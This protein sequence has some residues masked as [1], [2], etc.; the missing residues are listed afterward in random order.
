MYS[1]VSLGI[2]GSSHGLPSLSLW[3]LTRDES[4]L[5][6]QLE[7]CCYP[8]SHKW[9]CLLVQILLL[10]DSR[11]I[12]FTVHMYNELYST[13]KATSPSSI[14]SASAAVPHGLSWRWLIYQTKMP[15]I[16]ISLSTRPPFVPSFVDT[17]SLVVSQSLNS[18]QKAELLN[19]WAKWRL[20]CTSSL[21]SYSWI[22]RVRH[23]QNLL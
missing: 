9:L 18:C 16:E 2:S 19:E 13:V 8:P 17:F 15:N 7:G 6:G 14:A 23:G 5:G 21:C 1:Q 3:L 4:L 11:D 20:T 22:K 12:G 10:Q